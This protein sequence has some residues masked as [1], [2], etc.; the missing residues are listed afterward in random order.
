MKT[1]KVLLIII[2][3]ITEISCTQESSQT[4]SIVN[5]NMDETIGIIRPLHGG[6]LGPVSMLKT[7]DL[8]DYY[9]ECKIP[10]IR[11]EAV[12]WF[13]TNAVDIQTIFPDL[14]DDP[15]KADN[16]DF[17][18]TDDYMTTVIKTDA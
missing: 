15:S 10:L 8:T 18:Q 12:T 13:N 1:F 4:K 7:L 16:Y 2:L 11:L 9:K 6:T 5:I 14:R 17:R 3:T